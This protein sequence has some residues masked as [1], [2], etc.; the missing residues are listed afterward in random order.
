[1]QNEVT[2]RFYRCQPQKLSKCFDFF[3]DGRVCSLLLMRFLQWLPILLTITIVL[4][5]PQDVS[6]IRYYRTEN[7]LLQGVEIKPA[8]ARKFPHIEALYNGEGQLR[9]KITVGEDNIIS[10][11]EMY[12]Y[13]EDGSLWRRAV[14]D[15]NGNVTKMYVHGEEEM[16]STFISLVFPH[17][18]LADF[19]ERTTVYDYNID[20]KVS[21]YQFLSV[22]N[23]PF[24]QIEY[25]YF[26]EGLVKEELWTD[27]L[28][29]QT[30][31][32]F[33][34]RFN[35]ISRE[36]TMVE[37]DARGE[38]VSRV[39]I[40]LPRK[41]ITSGWSPSDTSTD[42]P[43]N[44]LEESSEIIEDILM[45]KAE[46]WNPDQSLGKL[47]DPKVLTSPDLITMKT[48]DTLKV[49]L[50]QITDEYVRFMLSGEHDVLTLPLTRV[51]EIERRDG[52]ILY[53][54]IYR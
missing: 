46:G 44:R 48:G 9:T 1:M 13:H 14:S 31:R 2:I 39:G 21:R 29:A 43:G 20:G 28:T 27:L 49:E 15:G 34:Y 33:K 30:V 35:P 12:E 54:V 50:I 32:L 23:T 53:P 22:D 52:E 24:G 38:E 37:H 10:E 19:D 11:Q 47:M 42:I 4:G 40:T 26:E 16:S 51:T 18:N 3:L 6:Y 17:R 36:Y 8:E 25:D 45:R 7:D 41:S 5:T